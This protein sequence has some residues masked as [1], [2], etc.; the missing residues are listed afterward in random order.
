MM[1]S[2]GRGSATQAAKEI[3][4]IPECVL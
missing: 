3:A 4:R 2:G 1:F